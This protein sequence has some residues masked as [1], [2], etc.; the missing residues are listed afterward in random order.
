MLSVIGN[1]WP[2]MDRPNGKYEGWRQLALLTT[3]PVVLVAG[4]VVGY[5]I[6]SFLDQRFGTS[7]WLMF[8]FTFMGVISGIKQT[9]ALIKKADRKGPD[10]N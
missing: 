10:G 2:E 3:I 1:R 6:G 8:F 5:L 9:I 4:P 7:P